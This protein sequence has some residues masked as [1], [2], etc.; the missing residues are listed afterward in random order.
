MQTGFHLRNRN[1]PPLLDSIRSVNLRRFID[2]TRNRLEAGQ[3][4]QHRI[5]HVA[6]YAQDRRAQIAKNGNPTATQWSHPVLSERKEH[7]SADPHWPSEQSGKIRTTLTPV[8][9]LGK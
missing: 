3:I 7:Y 9:I 2:F 5:S 4:D 8:I 1:I 6:P